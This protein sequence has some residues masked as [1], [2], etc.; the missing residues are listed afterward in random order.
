MNSEQQQGPMSFPFFRSRFPD[1]FYWCHRPL[2][3]ICSQFVKRFGIKSETRD[4]VVHLCSYKPEEGAW[5]HISLKPESPYVVMDTIRLD[6]V[7]IDSQIDIL[8]QLGF[9]PTNFWMNITPA[10]TEE[11]SET[12][13]ED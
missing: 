6:I 8:K 7:W 5:T 9:D 11:E 1:A 10:E 3:A 2:E 13:G 12:V 4:I